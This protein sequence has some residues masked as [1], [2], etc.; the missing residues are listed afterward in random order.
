MSQR[1]YFLGVGGTLMGSLALL[2]KEFGFDVA[3]SDVEVSFVL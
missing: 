1:V 2:A 3:G